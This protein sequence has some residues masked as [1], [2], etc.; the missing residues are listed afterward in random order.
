[1]PERAG[2]VLRSLLTVDVVLRVSAIVLAMLIVMRALF[3]GAAGVW[4]IVLVV[5]A[6]SALWGSVRLYSR[7]RTL[8]LAKA[9][10]D[11][12]EVSRL[13]ALLAS[14]SRS[15]LAA[16]L[17]LLIMVVHAAITG[18]V[19]LWTILVAVALGAIA[20]LLSPDLRLVAL[21]GGTALVFAAATVF[22]ANMFQ[23]STEARALA[24][25][26]AAVVLPVLVS[27]KLVKLVRQPRLTTTHHAIL[28]VLTLLLGFLGWSRDEWLPGVANSCYTLPTSTGITVLRATPDGKR[29]YGLLDTADPGVFGSPAFGRDP[30]TT[31]LENAILTRNSPLRPGDLTVVWLGALSCDPSPADATRCADGRDYPSERDQLRALLFAQ[32]QIADAGR[33]RLH[34]VIADATQDVAHAD[35]VAKLIVERRPALGPRAVV[36]GGGDSRDTTQRA[37]NRLLDAGIPF[38]A[39]N[40]L[41]DLGAPGRPFVDRPGYLQLAPPNLVYAQD[42]VARLAKRFPGGFRLDVYEQVNPA[43]KYTTSL[44]NDLL[45]AVKKA[46]GATARHVSSLDRVDA[47]ACKAS[48]P[49]VLFF[50]DRWTRFA[51]FAQRLNDLCGHARPQLV[52]ADGSVSRFMANYELRAVSNA[53]WPVDYYVGGPGCADLTQETFTKITNQ[54]Y[55]Q[56][57]LLHVEGVFTCADRTGGGQDGQLV[58]AC[59]LDAA[60]KLL[61]QPC[62]ADDLGTF[63]TPAWDAVFLAD[64]LLPA[65]PPSGE[66]YLT[67]LDLPATTLATGTVATVR[68]GKLATPTIPVRMWHVELLNDAS[69]IWERPSPTLRLP[70]DPA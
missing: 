30:V 42:T 55:A 70:T 47:S 17:A 41:A 35:D 22:A 2:R 28:A 5:A 38:I 4:S 15:R 19:G 61:S 69:R 34:V 60:V 46:P 50:A 45:A 68:A 56:R 6:A 36:I 37:I 62:Q 7:G 20:T 40:L 49:T 26:L 18:Y 13:A 8:L 63:L 51:D 33:H 67:S 32:K 21:L 11:E 10:A 31:G 23:G 59:T 9:G 39:P 12:A 54:M 16:V 43:D 1:M 25:S 14:R 29:C 57:E 65:A 3:A 58:Q 52:I 48:P 66:D 53:D 44:V 64:A 24:V 27:D